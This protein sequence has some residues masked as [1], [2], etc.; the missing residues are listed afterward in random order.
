VKLGGNERVEEGKK[1]KFLPAIE[2]KRK[3]WPSR[4]VLVVR[5]GVKRSFPAE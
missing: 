4:S 5:G 3:R 2:K 1:V